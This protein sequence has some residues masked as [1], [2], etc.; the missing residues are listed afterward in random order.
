MKSPDGHWI[1]VD[2]PGIGAREDWVPAEQPPPPGDVPGAWHVVRDLPDAEPRWEWHPQGAVTT[3]SERARRLR[4]RTTGTIGLVAA[5]GV[6]VI[7]TGTGGS[8]SPSARSASPDQATAASDAASYDASDDAGATVRYD[9]PVEK[10]PGQTAAGRTT[11]PAASEAPAGISTAG[12]RPQVPMTWQQQVAL[13]PDRPIRLD[14]VAA[15]WSAETI[16]VGTDLEQKKFLGRVVVRYT[17]PGS[18]SGAFAVTVLKGGKV[19]T[20][21]NG[22]IDDVRSGTYSVLLRSDATYTEGPFTTRFR[23]TS[24]A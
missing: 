22:L 1:T 24:T 9:R 19:V 4:T 2:V 5:L 11:G 12:A 10:H 14:P 20:T 21:L 13:A 15:D 7:V 8:D 18:A 23:V 17:G 16:V 3:S 6:A